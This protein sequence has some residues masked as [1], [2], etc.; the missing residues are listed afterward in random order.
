[1][2]TH[3]CGLIDESLTGQTVIL[4]GWVNKIRLQAH[5]D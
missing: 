5:V 1:M 4:C 2:R 3:H